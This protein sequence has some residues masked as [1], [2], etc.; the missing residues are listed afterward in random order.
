M[1]EKQVLYDQRKAE[2]K[3]VWAPRLDRWWEMSDKLGL[4]EKLEAKG[5]FSIQ[6]EICGPGIQK[7]RL[8]LTE[9]KLYVFNVYDI[10]N[11]QYLG[12][13]A[14]IAFCEDLD[15]EVVPIDG[16]VTIDDTYTVDKLLEMAEGKYESGHEREGIVVRPLKER[17]SH[18]LQGRT[19]FKAISNKFLLKTGE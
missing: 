4:K 12:Y 9:N 18:A 6:G 19:S 5:N 2:G 17:Y 7:N 16:F 15:L 13:E 8:K 3:E 14:F 11:A 10:D 1:E